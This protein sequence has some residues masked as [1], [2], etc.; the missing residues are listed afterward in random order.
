M[1]PATRQLLLLAVLV[2]V[3]GSGWCQLVVEDLSN[4]PHLFESD[5]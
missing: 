3:V 1:D 5:R 2:C 4:D